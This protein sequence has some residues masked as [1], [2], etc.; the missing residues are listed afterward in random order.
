M[1]NNSQ[2]YSQG[3]MGKSCGGEQSYEQNFLEEQ[4][5]N[6]HEGFKKSA[7]LKYN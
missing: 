6:N 1:K 2:H 4:R 3:R 5:R 7:L